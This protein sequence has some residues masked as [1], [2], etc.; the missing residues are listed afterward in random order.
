MFCM[1][2]R[3]GHNPPFPASL[4]LRPGVY[5][6]HPVGK[7]ATIQTADAEDLY[8]KGVVATMLKQSD[9]CVAQPHATRKTTTLGTKP[10]TQSSKPEA[11]SPEPHTS[12]PKSQ[13]ASLTPKSANAKHEPHL[14][15]KPPTLNP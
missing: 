15:A 12:D 1:R 13:T 11:P 14:Q 7:L 10:S 4:I 8:G 6:L 3:S 2:P 9:G 5:A